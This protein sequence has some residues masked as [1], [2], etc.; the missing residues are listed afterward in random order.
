MQAFLDMFPVKGFQ[1]TVSHDGQWARVMIQHTSY[2][3]EEIGS[4]C[5]ACARVRASSATRAI[6]GNGDQ[7]IDSRSRLR[8]RVGDSA[9]PQR[10][11]NRKGKTT[12][13]K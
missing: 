4:A 12:V 11:P 5:E 2:E 10:P 6:G 13:M 9:W 3:D 7:V 8:P 1:V